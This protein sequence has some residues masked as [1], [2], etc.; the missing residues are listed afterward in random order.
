VEGVAWATP[1]TALVTSTWGYPWMLRRL[2][3]ASSREPDHS[4]LQVAGIALNA[5][6][7]V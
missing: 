7:D 4:A 2:L 1:L 6:N 5:G 3:R